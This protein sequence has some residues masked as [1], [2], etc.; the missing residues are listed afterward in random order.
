MAEPVGLFSFES[1]LFAFRA[2]DF[3]VLL[4]LL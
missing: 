2:L 1:S 4:A 3:G